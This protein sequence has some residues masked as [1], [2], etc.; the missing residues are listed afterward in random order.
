[1]LFFLLYYIIIKTT[2][3]ISYVTLQ[4]SFNLHNKEIE[5]RVLIFKTSDTNFLMSKLL[6][7]KNSYDKTIDAKLIK[8]PILDGAEQG[9]SIG[10]TFCPIRVF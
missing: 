6:L 4:P 3:T 10:I 9:A 1:M 2:Y 5:F 8:G 7:P